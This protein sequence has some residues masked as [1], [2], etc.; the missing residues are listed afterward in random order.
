MHRSVVAA[1]TVLR[2]ACGG[3]STTTTPTPQPT[4][5]PTPITENLN[6]GLQLAP[7]LWPISG[8]TFTAQPGIVDVVARIDSP[9]P[10]TFRI[11]LL[12]EGGDTPHNEGSGGVTAQGPGPILTGR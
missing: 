9:F 1:L 6:Y 5:A 3:S 10:V 8:P 4:P 2:A 11:D 12:Y 7:T